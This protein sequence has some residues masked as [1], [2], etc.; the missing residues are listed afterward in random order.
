MKQLKSVFG[1]IKA[2]KSRWLLT[3][4]T[5]SAAG[6]FLWT[7]R[8]GTSEPT[9]QTATVEKGNI[10]STIS[11]S[12]NILTANTLPITTSATGI[13]KKVYVKDGNTVAKGQKLAEIELD[14]SGAQ[15]NAQAYASYISASNSLS[16]AKNNLRNAEASLAVVYDEIKGHDADESL[17]MKETRTKAEVAKDNAYLGV[18]NAQAS[19]SS[20]RLSYQE[21]NPIIYSPNSG[22]IENITLV[23]GM[24]LT[25]AASST[26]TAS[27]GESIAVIKTQGTPLA[28]FNISEID[29]SRVSQGQK[30]TITLDA[31]SDKTFTGKV[32]SVD[33]V[34]STSSGVTNYPVIIQ[35]DTEAAEILPNMAATANIILETK[36]NVLVIPSSAVTTSNGTST[37][38]IF[39]EGREQVVS[40]E[41]GLTGD[42][43]VEIISGLSEG[44]VVIT[45]TS[46]SVS[47]NTSGENRSVFSPGG[48]GGSGA[49]FR[50]EV[51]R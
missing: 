42:S 4:I 22:I 40:V 11:A 8:N 6:I 37:A 38:R 43:G 51:R 2:K 12:G 1:W 27:R 39:K 32:V 24:T 19:L 17:Q 30:A 15:N 26:D 33:K 36:N 49:V 25:S 50:T 10:I 13:V 29:V 14:P 23:E 9:Y 20:A 7:G 21:N 28:T 45:G 34:G 41:I 35:F 47:T 31:I 3:V 44:D 16:T 18:V 46:T 48:L 5:L